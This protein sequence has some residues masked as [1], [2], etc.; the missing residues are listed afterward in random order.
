MK[1]EFT[2]LNQQELEELLNKLMGD[3]S[4]IG[5]IK[6][7]MRQENQRVALMKADQFGLVVVS[8]GDDTGLIMTCIA[9][10]LNKLMEK[11][12]RSKTIIA[13]ANGEYNKNWETLQ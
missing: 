10:L 8:C 3:T 13:S 7:F 4:T 11:K 2:K 1:G 5:D 9:D 12:P 6:D